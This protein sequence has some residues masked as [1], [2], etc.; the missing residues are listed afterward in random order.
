M[1]ETQPR[2]PEKPLFRPRHEAPKILVPIDSAS[3]QQISA[4]EEMQI[5]ARA[6]AEVHR[7]LQDL[8]IS[9]YRKVLANRLDKLETENEEAPDNTDL[10]SNL[11]E[12]K[13][14]NAKQQEVD[15]LLFKPTPR[16]PGHKMQRGSE[17][18][19]N[20]A[21]RQAIEDERL[22]I[23]KETTKVNTKITKFKNELTTVNAERAKLHAWNPFHWGK[24]RDLDSR[25]G[26]IKNFLGDLKLR[27]DELQLRV[28]NNV[29]AGNTFL[30]RPEPIPMARPSAPIQWS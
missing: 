24:I 17:F 10:S 26:D 19:D 3:K 13:L 6:Q 2:S 23:R 22:E 30:G 9:A 21:R 27:N 1:S 5:I 29:L 16:I 20:F 28:K 4:N 15:R 18:T 25:I 8:D 11:A 7:D 12:I 14:I